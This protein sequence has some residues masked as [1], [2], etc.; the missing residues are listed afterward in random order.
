MV[1]TDRSTQFASA[2][3]KPVPPLP[4]P[5]WLYGSGERASR[6]APLAPA[7]FWRRLGL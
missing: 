5:S 2:G 1:R 7:E 4:H 3:A 6:A